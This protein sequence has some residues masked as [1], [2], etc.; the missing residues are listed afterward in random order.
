MEEI[1]R[2]GARLIEASLWWSDYSKRQNKEDK[3]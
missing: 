1:Q 2:T 3:S